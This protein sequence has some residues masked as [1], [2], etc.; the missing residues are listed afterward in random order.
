MYRLWGLLHGREN[1]KL[2][3]DWPAYDENVPDIMCNKTSTVPSLTWKLHI[4][5][6]HTRDFFCNEIKWYKYG[7]P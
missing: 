5:N 2:L 7:T 4:R 3:N 6:T 1:I